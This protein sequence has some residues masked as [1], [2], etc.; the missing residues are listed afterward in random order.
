MLSLA[1]AWPSNTLQ[2][3]FVLMKIFATVR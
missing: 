1:P 2:I 3:P